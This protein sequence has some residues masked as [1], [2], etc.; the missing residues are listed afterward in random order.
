MN[1]APQTVIEQT[2][3]LRGRVTAL[4]VCRQASSVQIMRALGFC[5]GIEPNLAGATTR[6]CKDTG[7]WWPSDYDG[8]P[9]LSITHE[10]AEDFGLSVGNTISLNVLGREITGEIANTRGGRESF[11]ICVHHVTGLLRALT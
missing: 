5:A 9:M 1:Q 10:M 11:I 8:P 4:T 7:S 2:P 6:R 3:M